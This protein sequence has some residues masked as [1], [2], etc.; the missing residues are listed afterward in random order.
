MDAHVLARL[1][2]KM[3]NR[4]RAMAIN[5]KSGDVTDKDREE[6]RTL[7]VIVDAVVNEILGEPTQD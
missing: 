3:R 2:Q 7:E 5:S 1:V 4:Q 6:A